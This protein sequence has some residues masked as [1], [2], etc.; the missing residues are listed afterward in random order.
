MKVNP[1]ATMSLAFLLQPMFAADPVVAFA[2]KDPVLS[3]RSSIATLPLTVSRGEASVLLKTAS[4]RTY[5]G[6][7]IAPE[8]ISFPSTYTRLIPGRT[9]AVTVDA[10]PVRLSRQ[11][12]Y[13]VTVDVT[14]V[15]GKPLSPH[16]LTFRYVVPEVTLQVENGGML[17]WTVRRPH[18]WAIAAEQREYMLW[19]VPSDSSLADMRGLEASLAIGS[20]TGIETPDGAKISPIEIDKQARKLVARISVPPGTRELFGA[21]RINGPGLKQEV[22]QP[23]IV[24]VKDWW[25][26][27]FLAIVAG[28]VL[29]FLATNRAAQHQQETLNLIHKQQIHQAIRDL[30]DRRRSTA[31]DSSRVEGLLHQANVAAISG[32][33]G[34]TKALLQ[35]ASI[36]L[37]LLRSTPSPQGPGIFNVHRSALTGEGRNFWLAALGA[38]LTL[39]AA[40]W[41][42][43]QSESFSGLGSYLAAFLGGFGIDQSI[44]GL[45]PI[46]NRS[47]RPNQVLT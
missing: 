43:W 47:R 41:V 15:T 33:V 13:P 34:K 10:D 1:F 23:V 6:I 32:D 9:S 28:Y 31:P 27:P 46:L 19:S 4:I 37:D 30:A 21:L 25:P 35:A 16:Q 3:S 7:A 39:F 40:F 2:D 26:F 38:I 11:G 17:I 18:P 20:A 5:D 45:A 36:A 8:A 22:T 44:Q 29:S 14:D 24:R 42:I 12:S